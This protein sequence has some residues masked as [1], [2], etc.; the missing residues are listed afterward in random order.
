LDHVKSAV[1]D[2]QNQ[3]N[4]FLNDIC[5]A[6]KSLVRRTVRGPCGIAHIYDHTVYLWKYI[7]WNLFVNREAALDWEQD[8]YIHHI[9]LEQARYRAILRALEDLHMGSDWGE[10]VE[11]GCSIGLFTKMLIGRCRSILA[12]DFSS[13]ACARTLQRCVGFPNVSIR[14]VNIEN[15]EISGQFDVLFIMDV[16]EL[17]HGRRSLEALVDR[18]IR[19]VRPGGYLVFS[20]CRL[21]SSSLRKAWWQRWFPE[22]AD[23][24]LVL[25]CGNRALQLVHQE[26]HA[27]SNPPDPR[28]DDHLSAIFKKS[29]MP[30]SLLEVSG[31]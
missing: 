22:G 4:T 5:T 6:A 31:G 1:G 16:M 30:A 13:V 10:V 15:D 21:W 25:L 11:I 23:Q 26:F 24:H 28:Y 14:K 27:N 18:L 19:R 29:A 3:P 2:G 8:R 20:G 9:P 17:I 12:C 7:I